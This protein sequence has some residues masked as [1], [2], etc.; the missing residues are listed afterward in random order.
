MTETS[1]HERDYLPAMGKHYLMPF[2]DL[3]HR[4][5]RLGRVHGEMVALAELGTGHQVLDVG[6]GTG[7]LLRAAGRS[8]AGLTGVDPDLKLLARAERRLRRA[9]VK[10]RLDRGYAQE[11]PYPDASFDRVFS[12]LM[13]HHLDGPSKGEMLAEVR[14]VLKPGGVFVLADMAHHGHAR[15]AIAAAGF[16]VEPTRTVELR[17]FGPVGIE[18]ATV[19]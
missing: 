8:G 16:T 3:L 19:H 9:G 10:A 17:S 12:S 4:V 15:E 2:Y 14:R 7:N 18:V 6:C 1:S 13:L 5:S 11:L